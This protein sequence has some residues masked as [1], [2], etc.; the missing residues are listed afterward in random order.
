MTVKW[1]SL[2]LYCSLGTAV[3]P[4][5]DGF[6]GGYDEWDRGMTGFGGGM[7]GGAFLGHGGPGMDAFP[8]AIWSG[9][10]YRPLSKACSFVSSKFFSTLR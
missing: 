3:K 2:G 9:G 8:G 6:G 7:T 1:V 5:Y 4:R 10:N